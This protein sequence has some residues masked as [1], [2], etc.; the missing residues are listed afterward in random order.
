[1][2]SLNL[3]VHFD[4]LS[5]YR[6][7]FLSKKRKTF[8]IQFTHMPSTMLGTKMSVVNKTVWFSCARGLVTRISSAFSPLPRHHQCQI[9]L[10]NRPSKISITS[11]AHSAVLALFLVCGYDFL[12]ALLNS[13]FLK[14]PCPFLT[15]RWFSY[16]VL[17]KAK[18]FTN[19]L[20]FFYS[21]SIIISSKKKYIGFWIPSI[22]MRST[23]M[24]MMMKHRWT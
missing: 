7:F 9:L 2:M 1:M 12:F 3:L 13:D 21:I 20:F 24:K 22:L 23:I 15:P 8:H 11:T 18:L 10:A 19:E 16:W 4:R 5:H 6:L 14:S 17:L